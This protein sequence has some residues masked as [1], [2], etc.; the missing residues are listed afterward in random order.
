MQLAP[1]I[2]PIATWYQGSL[3]CA[4]NHVAQTAKAA[5][6]PE[7]TASLDEAAGRVYIHESYIYELQAVNPGHIINPD[8]L[9]VYN[10]YLCAL[11]NLIG[12]LT[13]PELKNTA[14]CQVCHN[15]YMRLQ[16]I[17]KIIYYRGY[18][19][20]GLFQDPNMSKALSDLAFIPACQAS[21]Q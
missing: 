9:F 20:P 10:G 12:V 16:E 2:Y 4:L 6:S 15:I 17:L 14:D 13:A 8:P 19:I 18:D 21:R 7:I 1:T 3:S 11:H 5:A